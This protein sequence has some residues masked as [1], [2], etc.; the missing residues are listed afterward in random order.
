MYLVYIT[1]K[2]KALKFSANIFNQVAYVLLFSWSSNRV[3]HFMYVL[4][5]F[6]D[7]RF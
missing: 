6:K 4:E 5:Y 1:T 3:W 2:N 7:T